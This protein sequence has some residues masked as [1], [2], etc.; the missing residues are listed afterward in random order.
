MLLK[1]PLGGG[2]HLDSSKLVSIGRVSA[3]TFKFGRKVY[4]P[5]LLETRDDGA[6]QSTLHLGQHQ[7]QVLVTEGHTWTPSG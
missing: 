3:K 1:V 7:F 2:N 5:S 6:N 4:I